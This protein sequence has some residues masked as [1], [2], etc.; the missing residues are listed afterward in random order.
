MNPVSDQDTAS[1]GDVRSDAGT[2]G[3]AAAAGGTAP[4]ELHYFGVRHHGPGC[5]RSLLRALDSLRPDCVLIEG[6]PEADALV[7]DVLAADMVPPVALLTHGVEEP[8][9]AVYH[10]FAEFSPE[11]QAL[12]WAARA[13]ATVRFIDLPVAIGLARDKAAEER[14]T[15]AEMAA[16]AAADVAGDAASEPTENDADAPSGETDSTSATAE[17]A[18]MP[19]ADRRED[20]LD[21]LARA[22]G[23]SDGEAWWNHMVE[24]RGDGEQLFA[25]IEEAMLAVRSELPDEGRFPPERLQREALREAHMRQCIRAARKEGFQRIAVIC[26]AWHLGGLKADVTVKADQALLKGLPKLKVTSTWVP[27]TY[28]HLAWQSGYGAGIQSPGWYEHL[29]RSSAD[30]GEDVPGQHAP[31]S[32]AVGWLARVARLM[33][34]RDLDCS[35][36]HLIEAARLADTLAALR[37]R[38]APGLEELH[39]ATRTVMTL[40]DDALLDFIREELVIG[41]R[42]GQVPATVPKVPLQRDLEQS[43]KSLRLK[44]EAVQKTLDLDLRQPN[45]LARSH[46]L[47]RLSLVGVAW[48][49]LARVGRS[50]RGTFHEVWTLQWEPAFAVRLIEASRYGQTVE[51]AATAR[52]AERCEAAKDLATLAELVDQVLLADLPQAVAIA[53]QALQDHAALTGDASQLMTALPPLANVFR[54][55]NVR[56]TDATLVGQVF[57]GLVVRAAIGLPLVGRSIDDAAAEQLRQDLLAAHA[58][59]RLRD[60]GRQQE[61]ALQWQRAIRQLAHAGSVHELLQGV[62]TRLMLDDGALSSDEAAQ[63]LSLHLSSGAEPLKAAAWLDGFL[64]R[65]A[66]VLLHHDGVWPLVDQWLASLSEEHFVRVLPLVRRTFSAFEPGERRDLGARAARKGPGAG[67]KAAASW[68]D[69]RAVRPLPLLRQLLGVA[70]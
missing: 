39:E 15:A 35:S 36:A 54:Y 45:D 6:P 47:H 65:N 18:A 58:A 44:P 40:G 37:Q 48:G 68:D 16:E 41:D 19:D 20:P 29:W 57:D 22:A 11:W 8:G 28:R 4:G 46:L 51:A 25:A 2:G 9:R 10:P 50:S 33:R 52:V 42:L 49:A 61:P 13:G 17:V 21:W 63:A 62:A 26:G 27:W 56:Q 23:Y 67:Q 38:P 30:A 55:G 60:P 34:A 59:I 5:A 70:T 24:E 64:N 66:V 32:R 3:T 31:H 53:S 1:A 14:R 69:A 12:R 7:A 43:Q